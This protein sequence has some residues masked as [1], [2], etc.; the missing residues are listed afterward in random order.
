MPVKIT[1]HISIFVILLSTM[2]ELDFLYLPALQGLFKSVI[3]S[4]MTRVGLI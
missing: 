1:T 2:R 4:K 3:T